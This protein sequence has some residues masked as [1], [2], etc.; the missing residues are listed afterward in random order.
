MSN[1]QPTIVTI[2]VWRNKANDVETAA[3]ALTA[4]YEGRAIAAPDT[5]YLNFVS[6]C[7]A[8]SR[9]GNYTHDSGGTQYLKMNAE[10]W[11][12]WHEVYEMSAASRVRYEL[13]Q[14]AA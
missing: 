12:Q 9:W 13:E 6:D 7:S 1:W 10:I 4:D 3:F 11:R 8:W 5:E 14:S 2:A